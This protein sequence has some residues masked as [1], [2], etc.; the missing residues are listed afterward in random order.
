MAI[1]ELDRL[2]ED[3][4]ARTGIPG[5]AVAV[6]VDNGVA[7][8]KGFGLREEGKPA[9]VDADTVFQLASVSKSVGA[10]VVAHEVGAGKVAWDSRM[11]E[12]LP[13]FA[14]ADPAAT[15]M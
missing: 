12:L 8:A 3:M 13:W 9:P 1:G 11:A 6:V 2:V 15:G 14:L 7:Y 5:V 10:T 4:R